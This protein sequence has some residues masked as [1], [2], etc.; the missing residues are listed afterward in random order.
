MHRG[1]YSRQE[2]QALAER[3]RVDGFCVLPDH[4][5]EEKLLAWR[6]SL[7]P[8]IAAHVAREENDS[9]RGAGRF[10]VTLPFVEPFADEDIFVDPD[11]LG[12]VRGLVGEDATVDEL[13]ADTVMKGSDSREIQRDSQPL[14]PES[15]RETP[16][17]LLAVNFPLAEVTLE[18]GP[19]EVARGT[20]GVTKE[21]GI[22]LIESG[23]RPLEPLAMALGD[24]LIRD[25]RLLHRGAPN[26]TDEPCSTV[27][28]GYSRR[29]LFRPEVS[30]EIPRETHE[31][32]GPT[33]RYLLRFNPIVEKLEREG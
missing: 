2:R 28:I 18:N 19:L 4:L 9:N 13:A 8:I 14:F 33:A 15:G 17:Y 21:E 3:V 20:H 26:R 11:I 32:L 5:P 27:V 29:W 30:I 24:V 23:E 10:H 25:V 31:R 22:R 16:A 6:Q 12:I 1:Y 7:E